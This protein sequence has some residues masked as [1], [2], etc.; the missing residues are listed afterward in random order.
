MKSNAAGVSLV[1]IALVAACSCL[2]C[3]PKP[4][5]SAEHA[6]QQ[7]A[8]QE[9]ALSLD[10]LRD[11]I[12]A[13]IGEPRCSDASQCRAI[14]FGA[15]PC[16]GPWQ[17]LVYSTAIADSAVLAATVA[18]Y[19][20]EEARLNEEEGRVSDC[21]AVTHPRLACLEQRCATTQR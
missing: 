4:E 9:R 20:A 5:P 18:D 19:N 13:A 15:K 7:L 16:G 21:R 2:G 11:A 17:Y 3:G 1:G 8:M 12:L 10:S 6:P 14:A